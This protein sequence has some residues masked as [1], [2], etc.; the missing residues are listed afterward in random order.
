[1]PYVGNIGYEVFILMHDNV[2]PHEPGKVTNFPSEVQNETS[3][4]PPYSTDLKAMDHLKCRIRWRNPV[5]WTKQELRTAARALLFSISGRMLANAC[6]YVCPKDNQMQWNSSW[7]PFHF[8]VWSTI[9]LVSSI[10]TISEF[11][12]HKKIW[13]LWNIRCILFH[14]CLIRVY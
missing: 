3:D 12:F 2:R 13:R 9:F 4:W 14:E 8:E 10:F 11:I 6:Y 7:R 5:A 1:M